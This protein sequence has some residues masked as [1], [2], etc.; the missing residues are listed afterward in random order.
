MPGYDKIGIWGAVLLTFLRL[1]QG[2]GVGGE[3]GGRFCS[4]WSG[5]DQQEPRLHRPPGRN[6]A[7]PAGLF[8]ANVAVLF[9]S[10]LSG[11]QFLVWGWRIPFLISIVMVAI[12]VPSSSFPPSLPPLFSPPS[13][14]HLRLFR[15]ARHRDSTLI[16]IAVAVSFIPGMVMYGPE[17]ALIAKR[18]RHGCQQRRLDRLSAG[19]D[20]RRPT[21]A[22]RLDLAVFDLQ[23]GGPDRRLC[24]R[25]RGDQHLRGLAAARPDQQGHRARGE[26]RQRVRRAARVEPGGFCELAVRKACLEV[27]FSHDLRANVMRS[28]RGKPLAAFFRDHA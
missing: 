11:D 15:D 10:W 3:W 24:L 12:G 26:L 5:P 9:F 28:S 17:A 2:I 6:S 1:I 13:P 25:L 4:R 27:L 20:H 18:S 16:F 8:L 23:I 14:L 21:G 22:V 7:R 19:L